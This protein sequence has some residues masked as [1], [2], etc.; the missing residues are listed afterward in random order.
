MTL[1]RAK[2]IANR[3]A[4]HSDADCREAL[5]R[6]IGTRTNGGVR[7]SERAQERLENRIQKITDHLLREI[8]A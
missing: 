1:T 7:N 5:A 8:A 3:P 6:L 2:E 4:E